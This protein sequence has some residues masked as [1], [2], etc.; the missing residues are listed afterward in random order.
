MCQSVRIGVFWGIKVIEIMN[1]L[2]NTTLK[3]PSGLWG[4]AEIRPEMAEKRAFHR[5][6]FRYNIHLQIHMVVY[7]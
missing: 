3:H 2:K 1:L 4:N 7:E 5:Q 6:R